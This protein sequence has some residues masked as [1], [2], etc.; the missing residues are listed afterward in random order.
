MGT[1]PINIV[2]NPKNDDHCLS[3]TT[4]SGKSTIDPSFLVVDESMNDSIVVVETPD[5]ESEK[6]TGVDDNI[7][8]DKGNGK[9]HELIVKYIT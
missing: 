7:E 9:I 3:I 8:K 5:M 4:W 1:L 6:A 2:Q